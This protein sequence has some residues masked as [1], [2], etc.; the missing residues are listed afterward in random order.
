MFLFGIHE[1]IYSRIEFTTP[2][3][4]WKRGLSKSWFFLILILIS[5]NFCR[6]GP[7]MKERGGGLCGKVVFTLKL[8]FLH[9]ICSLFTV[10]LV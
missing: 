3:T 2:V 9:R 4:S 10:A 1:S 7:T 5:E 8:S 6:G